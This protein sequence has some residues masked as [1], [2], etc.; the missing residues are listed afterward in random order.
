MSD[1]IP[2]E[3][4][5]RRDKKGYPTPVALWLRDG[6]YQETRE[7]LLSSSSREPVIFDKE[8]VDKLMKEHR[9]GKKDLSW[10]IFRWI[11]CKLWFQIFLDEGSSL[12]EGITIH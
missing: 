1:L 9:S 10:E 7:Y 12:D 2:R 11:T 5:N 6:L 4:L 8:K 3:I